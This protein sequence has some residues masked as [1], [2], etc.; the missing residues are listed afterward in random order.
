MSTGTRS[1][2][3]SPATQVTGWAVAL[4]AADGDDDERPG[5][6]GGDG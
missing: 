3:D 4:A 6:S 1:A 2:R 5:R